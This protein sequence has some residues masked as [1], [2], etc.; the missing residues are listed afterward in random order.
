MP[1]PQR[2]SIR[3][4]GGDSS[5]LNIGDFPGVILMGRQGDF[6]AQP[7]AIALDTDAHGYDARPVVTTYTPGTITV[8]IGIARTPED[9]L[10]DINDVIA[11]QMRG[12]IDDET[13]NRGWLY[14]D[15]L[16]FIAAPDSWRIPVVPQPY[17]GWQVA[18]GDSP[19]RHTAELK[20]TT[21]ARGWEAD[22]ATTL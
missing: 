10:W 22:P 15:R 6:G 20:F 3:F 11:S 1:D 7:F 5:E 14:F 17:I 12:Q 4:M 18:P 19:F 21:L 8:P 9:A 13:P 16:K 2:W